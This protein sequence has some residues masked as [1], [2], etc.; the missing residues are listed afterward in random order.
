MLTGGALACESL[1]SEAVTEA[2][3][4]TLVLELMAGVVLFRHVGTHPCG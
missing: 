1:E 2:V 4:F 3:P